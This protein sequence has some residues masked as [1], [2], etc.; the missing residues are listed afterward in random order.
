MAL[1]LNTTP[2]HAARTMHVTADGKRFCLGEPEQEELECPM[3]RF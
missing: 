3:I 1:I 2:C